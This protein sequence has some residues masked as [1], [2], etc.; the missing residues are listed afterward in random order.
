MLLYG[1]PYLFQDVISLFWIR[2]NHRESGMVHCNAFVDR[3]LGGRL[4]WLRISE[5]STMIIESVMIKN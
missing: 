4:S 2:A 5:I 1:L 3:W